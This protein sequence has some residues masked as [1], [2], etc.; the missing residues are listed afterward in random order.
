MHKYKISDYVW[1]LDN[2]WSRFKYMPKLT[3]SKIKKISNE[4]VRMYLYCFY[5]Y[6][7]FF[8]YVNKKL[9][10]KKIKSKNN[11]YLFACYAGQLEI[12]KYLVVPQKPQI[13]FWAI[14][15]I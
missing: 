3:Q 4:I 13:N 5:G 8:L 12:I 10:K 11:L 2:Y 14:K 1:S 7:E 6:K 9:L 15:C